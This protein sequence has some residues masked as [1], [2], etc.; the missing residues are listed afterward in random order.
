VRTDLRRALLFTG[1][2]DGKERRA[3]YAGTNPYPVSPGIGAAHAFFVEG[4]ASALTFY[5]AEVDRMF[6]NEPETV[7]RW[8]LVSTVPGAQHEVISSHP[9]REQA[10]EARAGRPR[11]AVVGPVKWQVR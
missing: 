8:L 2:P 3:T 7:V 11:S 4:H 10:T 6:A 9:T 1:A 5:E